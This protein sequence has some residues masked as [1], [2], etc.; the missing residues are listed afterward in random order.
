MRNNILPK[1]SVHYIV[2]HIIKKLSKIE[3][4]ELVSF[5]EDYKYRYLLDNNKSKYLFLFSNAY[6]KLVSKK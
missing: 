2:K 6:T 5:L 1:T 4:R 3:Q